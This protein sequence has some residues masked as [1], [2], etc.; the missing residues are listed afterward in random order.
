MH[1][2]EQPEEFLDV[3]LDY[4]MAQCGGDHV[5]WDGTQ[6][7]WFH[8]PWMHELREPLHGLTRERSSRL[9]ELHPSQTMRTGNWAVSLYNDIGGYG[10]HRIWGEDRSFPKT[11]G[12]AFDDGD[13]GRQTIVLARD[14]GTGAIPSTCKNLE[15]V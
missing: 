7:G 10:F 11:D 4:A 8:A 2:I 6:C 13:D 12:F 15:D 5:D 9:G 1:P 3:V 14:T